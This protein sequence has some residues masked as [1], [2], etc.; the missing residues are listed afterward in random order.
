MEMIDIWVFTA[1]T[2]A[3]PQRKL[4]SPKGA[5]HQDLS[6]PSLRWGDALLEWQLPPQ[7]PP[8]PSAASFSSAS[9]SSSALLFFS[10]AD[11]SCP[12]AAM[13]SRPRG[14]RT[15]AEMPAS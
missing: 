5:H 10:E 15:G 1:V 6:D 7:K 11:L 14:V 8:Y 13:M 3:S 12:Q 4:G 9:R 2:P